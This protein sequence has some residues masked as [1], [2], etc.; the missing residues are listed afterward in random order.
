MFAI[1]TYQ[2]PRFLLLGGVMDQA[3][4][5]R[6]GI[7]AGSTLATNEAKAFLSPCV[8][9]TAGNI[10]DSAGLSLHVGDLTL[11]Q[12]GTSDHWAVNSLKE[13]AAM[14]HGHLTQTLKLPMACHTFGL[15]ASSAP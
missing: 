8:H 2:W 1:S 15:A 12:W 3:C 13:I 14:V 4:C 11:Q 7:V 9:A 5:P 6:R 10:G